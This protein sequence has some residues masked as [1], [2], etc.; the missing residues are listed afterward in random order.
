MKIIY[1]QAAD[2]AYIQ[3]VTDH[4]GDVTD[5]VAIDRGA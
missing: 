4:F 5:M 3:R 2:A 1:N